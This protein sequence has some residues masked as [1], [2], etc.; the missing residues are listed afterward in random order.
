MLLAYGAWSFFA[1]SSPLP[2]VAN[3]IGDR[4]FCAPNVWIGCGLNANTNAKTSATGDYPEILLCT[5][6]GGNILVWDEGRGLW[7]DTYPPGE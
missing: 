6:P 7:V 4:S 2:A 1:G 3:H 5:M